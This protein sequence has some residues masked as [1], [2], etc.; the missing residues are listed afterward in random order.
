M[1]SPDTVIERR[2]IFYPE[3]ELLAN[4]ANFDLTSEEALFS[5]SDGVMLH[6]W[7]VPGP[8]EISW[9]WLHGNGGNISHRLENLHLIHHRLGVN[10]LLFDYRGYGHSEGQPSEKGTYR[11]AEGAFQ[12]LQSRP[13][14]DPSK[15]VIFGCSLGCAVAVELATRCE[16]YGLILESPFTSV[17]DMAK[18]ALPFP[19]VTLFVRKKY[20]SLSKIGRISPPLLV[21]HGN[22]DDTV[23]F[24]MG[25]RLF[26]AANQPKTFYAINGAGHNDTYIVGGESY[27]AA[28]DDFLMRL[29]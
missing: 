12:Y 21:L 29:P 28:I 2:F 22:Q 17:A 10:V 19:G 26:E 11:D 24:E 13:D 6:G 9:L 1:T 16:P 27:F 8:R 5:A 25:E 18:R 20:D 14:I 3:R 15:I 7:F 23:P 4:P